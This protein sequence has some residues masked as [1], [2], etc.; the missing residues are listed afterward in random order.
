MYMGL[1]YPP[2]TPVQRDGIYTT[3]TG[4]FDYTLGLP[5]PNVRVRVPEPVVDVHV[6][7]AVVARVVRV[8]ANVEH[9]RTGTGK[10][11]FPTRPFLRLAPEK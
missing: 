2:V 11:P 8:T 6:A 10:I 1:T 7:W 9:K 3:K 5:R 4:H